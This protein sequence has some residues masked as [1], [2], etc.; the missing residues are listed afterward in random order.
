MPDSMAAI[1][2]MRARLI[3]THMRE[4]ITRS[5][6]TH[7]VMQLVRKCLLQECCL[8]YEEIEEGCEDMFCICK[9]HHG[10]VINPHAFMNIFFWVELRSV[11]SE[12]EPVVNQWQLSGLAPNISCP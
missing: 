2:G 10:H 8:A 7:E 9:L 4:Y 11:C 1:Y 12:Y 3:E 5:D 6:V